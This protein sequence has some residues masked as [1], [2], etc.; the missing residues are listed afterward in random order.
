MLAELD[1]FLSGLQDDERI[2]ESFEVLQTSSDQ[3]RAAGQE[4]IL[5]RVNLIDHMLAIV[6]E[7]E[8][9]GAVVLRDAA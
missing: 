8:I 2:V 1:A 7:T 9:G 5:M 4:R 6:L 3:Q